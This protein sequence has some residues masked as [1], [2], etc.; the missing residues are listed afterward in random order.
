MTTWTI[1]IVGSKKFEILAISNN[2]WGICHVLARG[3]TRKKAEEIAEI[4]KITFFR[5]MQAMKDEIQWTELPKVEVI[6]EINS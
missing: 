5:G 6:N 2:N 1:K 4:V 3:L